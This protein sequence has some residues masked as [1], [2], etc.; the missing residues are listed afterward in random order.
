M[1]LLISHDELFSLGYRDLVFLRCKVCHETFTRTRNRVN[2]VLKGKYP[3]SL[4]F[5]GRACR[6]R[7]MTKRTMVP[8]LL[9]GKLVSRRLCDLKTYSRTY[10]SKSCAMKDRMRKGELPR[11]K[12]KRSKAEAY[13]SGRLKE[14]FP[15]F[16]VL[17]NSRDLLPQ[18]LEIDLLVPAA[19]VAIELNG[20]THYLPIFGE[21]ELEKV[22][23]RDAIKRDML[24]KEGYEFVTIDIS[25]TS[26]W[27][28]VTAIIDRCYEEVIHPALEA[29]ST[30]LALKANVGL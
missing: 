8:C 15:N 25:S 11:K 6:H 26:K 29:C 24:R 17:E 7:D 22:K 27:K 19:K 9:C 5:C 23:N 4:D 20:P 28:K 14:G 18:R 2:D 10:C 12:F 1:E 30:Q 3:I 16:E 13:L 21:E